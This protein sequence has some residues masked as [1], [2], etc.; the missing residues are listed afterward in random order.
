MSSLEKFK[1]TAD[2]CPW[3]R[4]VLAAPRMGRINIRNK[5]K[6]KKTEGVFHNLW[7]AGH[8]TNAYIPWME[9]LT[10]D[11]LMM[12]TK[13]TQGYWQIKLFAIMRAV[14]QIGTNPVVQTNWFYIIT[15]E[16]PTI[17]DS[18]PSCFPR[19]SFL[20]IHESYKSLSKHWHRE[21]FTPHN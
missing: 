8:I 21:L 2:N 13:C 12:I 20:K 5:K 15:T 17:S 19:L 11:R 14:F 18:F 6:Q 3:G 4:P 10:H 7:L 1:C 9:I 16:R